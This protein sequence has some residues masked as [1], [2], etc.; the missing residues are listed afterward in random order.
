MPVDP[1]A[2]WFR[3]TH[4]V[5]QM[6]WFE[7]DGP[8]GFSNQRLP[9]P[10]ETR[11]SNPQLVTNP[12][13]TY[14][15]EREFGLTDDQINGLEQIVAR[16]MIDDGAIIYVNDHLIHHLP[17]MVIVA[18]G[19]PRLRTLPCGKSRCPNLSWSMVFSPLDHSRPSPGNR[20]K[21]RMATIQIAILFL[22]A[23]RPRFS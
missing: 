5:D 7:A 15:F 20:V 22:I 6:N 2:N 8:L 18:A 19:R 1:G 12:I 4:L 13:T 11:F 16:Q 21:W 10:L 14:Y 3:E 17:I 9:V 23:T